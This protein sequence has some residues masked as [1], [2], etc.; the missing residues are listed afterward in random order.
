MGKVYVEEI[1]STEMLYATQVFSSYADDW[2][3][4]PSP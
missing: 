4:T 1:K 2:L 3:V